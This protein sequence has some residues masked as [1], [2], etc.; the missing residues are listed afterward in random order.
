[1]ISLSSMQ[2]F[3]LLFRFAATGQLV[4]LCLLFYSRY[5]G[6][7]RFASLAVLV[8]ICAYILLTTPIEDE[9]YAWLRQP[10][11]LLT[12]L[13]S[14][15]ILLLAQVILNPKLRFKHISN[16]WS[17]PILAWCIFLG[18]FF[19]FTPGKGEIHDLNHMLGFAILLLVIYQCLQGYRDDL[20]DSRRKQRLVLV[21]GCGVYMLVLTFFE[22]VFQYV[23][24]GQL[25][26][27]INAAM[28]FTL[29]SLFSFS[30][31]Q[32]K[33]A[34]RVGLSSE[35]KKPPMEDPRIQ[36]LNQLMQTGF[37]R[38][39]ELTVGRLALE[40]ELAEH[41]LRQLI[42]QKLGFSNFSHYLNSYRIPAICLQL[43]DNELKHI[44]I[45]TLALDMGYGSIASFNRAFKQHMA[46]TPSEY[47][48]QF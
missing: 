3:D 42:N 37:Y 38:Q 22:L 16:W 14:Y 48:R 30:L 27:L 25:F 18:Y 20:L 33:L 32:R 24:D 44:P 4:L 28:L 1:M 15:G 29:L 47:R 17:V 5:K 8:C 19:L 46:K 21:I 39:P 11:L 40:L 36:Q 31:I 10:L 23:K 45:L 12:D 2:V 43:A 13:T 35:Q 7:R 9:H 41:K 6:I 34:V 26:S